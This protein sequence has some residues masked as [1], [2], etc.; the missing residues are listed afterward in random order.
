MASSSTTLLWQSSSGVCSSSASSVR[1][2]PSGF[3]IALAPWAFS[4]F[5]SVI[6][7][8]PS[9]LVLSF[10]TTPGISPPSPS[11]LSL[12]SRARSVRIWKENVAAACLFSELPIPMPPVFFFNPFEFP[13]FAVFPKAIH[14]QLRVRRKKRNC[15]P[16]YF[17]LIS[18]KYSLKLQKNTKFRLTFPKSFAKI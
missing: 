6:L 2:V 10:N 14:P 12:S 9:F 15:D 1:Y 11:K 5:T 16:S 13:H 17:P 7:T 4:I 8:A 3:P 18:K